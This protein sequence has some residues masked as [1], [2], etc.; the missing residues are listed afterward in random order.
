MGNA[1]ADMAAPR[2]FAASGCP[3]RDR[4]SYGPTVQPSRPAAS[5]SGCSWFSTV[6]H[7]DLIHSGSVARI[8]RASSNDVDQVSQV[9]VIEG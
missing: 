7:G 9:A 1:V 3:R 2:L 5:W 6:A 4:I 8:G